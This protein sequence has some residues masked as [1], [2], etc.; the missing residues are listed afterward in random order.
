VKLFSLIYQGDVHPSTG[1]KR[2]PAS[3]Y[4]QLASAMEIV[5]KAQEDAASLIENT[6]K[7]CET[8]KQGATEEGLQQGL[9]KFNEHVFF[10]DKELKAIRHSLQQMVLP[11]A[12][13]A[14]KRIVS[15]EL[16]THPETIV[17]I[18]LQA[19]APIAESS[20]VT[21]YCNKEDKEFLDREKPKLKEILQQAEIVTIQEKPDVERGGCIIQTEGGMIN[22]TIENQWR[23]LERAFE[24]YQQSE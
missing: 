3:E 19:I 17:D 16:E 21:I 4:T 5:E 14:A 13:K 6:K 10:L 24:K 12:L 23:A 22:A 1:K 18:V 8:M 9:E 2:I 7:Q 15:K 20:K 11:I